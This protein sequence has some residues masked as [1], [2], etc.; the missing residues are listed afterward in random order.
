LNYKKFYVASSVTLL[1]YLNFL[2]FMYAAGVAPLSNVDVFFLPI[3]IMALILFSPRQRFLQFFFAGISL[4]LFFVSYTLDGNLIKQQSVTDS[5]RDTINMVNFTLA[6]VPTV[7]IMRH[8]IKLN[9][10]TQKFLLKKEADLQKSRMRYELAISGSNSGIYEW[11]IQTDIVYNSP[12]W[13]KMLG[14]SEIELEQLTLSSFLE[15][16]HPEDRERVGKAVQ[17]HITLRMPYSIEFKIRKKDGTYLWVSD[18]GLASWNEEGTPEL[19]VGTLTDISIRKNSEL[20]ILQQNQELAKTNAELDQFVYRAS[21]DLRAPL[22]SIMGLVE[23]GL[24][25]NPDEMKFCFQMINERAQAQDQFIHDIISYS[26]NARLTPSFE[27]INIKTF[28]LETIQTLFFMDGAEKIKINVEASAQLEIIT[29]PIRLRSIIN[30]L[31]SNAIKYR[32]ASKSLQFITVN[33]TSDNA[34][35]VLGVIDNGI[36]IVADRQDKI[37]N[38]FYRGTERSSGSGLGLFIVKEMVEKLGGS[39]NFESEYGKGS[40]FKVTLPTG[41][42][43]QS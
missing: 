35:W 25:A 24:R 34:N 23:I 26:R 9:E 32:D 16:V 13:K 29:D 15:M 39:I 4:V 31:V 2:I 37:F 18:T 40:H 1:S 11:N 6:F 21:H 17:D 10:G 22:A 28:A 43:L 38:M 5:E 33:C 42:R 14:Y 30:N 3:G 12:F 7:L 8:L 36:G 20:K 27:K 41:I 19:M